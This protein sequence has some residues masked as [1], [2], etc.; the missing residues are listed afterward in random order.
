MAIKKR[1]TKLTL[2]S[3]AEVTV[4]EGSKL[5]AA[6]VEAT[7]DLNLYQGVRLAQ[8]FEAIYNQGRK[9]GAKAA[10]EEISRGF[11]EAQKKIPHRA[12]GRPKKGK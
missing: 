11:T 9:D 12:P 2:Y 4:Y 10:F 6:L 3:G 5:Q 1:K 8:V 7:S